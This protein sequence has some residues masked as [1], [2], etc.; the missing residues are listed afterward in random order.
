[1]PI[2]CIAITTT[3]DANNTIAIYNGHGFFEP[4]PV[5]RPPLISFDVLRGCT[6]NDSSWFGIGWGKS[7]G[8]GTGGGG[9][10]A[11]NDVI[12]SSGISCFV[13]IED[14]CVSVDFCSGVP[15]LISSGWNWGISTVFLSSVTRI[16][17]SGNR[18][19]VVRL[20]NTARRSSG[21]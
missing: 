12:G 16:V 21:K 19:Y 1:M 9:M 6:I 5:S 11:T 18:W 4:F 14:F 17:C 7:C 3:P 15:V 20:D 10:G 8:F 13:N 2:T